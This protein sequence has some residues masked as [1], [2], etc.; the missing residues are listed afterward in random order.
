MKEFIIR[1]GYEL[2]D[3]L[4]YNSYRTWERS[5]IRNYDSLSVTELLKLIID[6]N[7]E[8]V[9]AIHSEKL[10]TACDYGTQIHKDLEQYFHTWELPRTPI[11]LNFRR[12]LVEKDIKILEAE[13]TYKL[14]IGIWFP[15]TAMLDTKVKIGKQRWTMD[16]KCSRKDRNFITMKYELQWNFYAM[17]CWEK[18]AWNLYLNKKRYKLIKASDHHLVILDLIA[19]A[20]TLVEK[21]HTNNLY[22]NK[23]SWA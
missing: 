23:K 6:P 9:K 2:W 17:M 7:M 16:Y 22:L 19:Y 13:K 5:E 10:Q 3:T 15:L 8:M 11:H 4:E 14:D 1:Y 12:A 18:N 20:K 21:W